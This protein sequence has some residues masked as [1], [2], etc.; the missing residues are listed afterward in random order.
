MSIYVPKHMYKATKNLV[1]YTKSFAFKVADWGQCQICTRT[2]Q[3]ERSLIQNYIIYFSF[4]I[5]T[6][7]LIFV[8]K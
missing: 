7:I 1:L 8:K 4:L 6:E 2:K 3:M 5:Q